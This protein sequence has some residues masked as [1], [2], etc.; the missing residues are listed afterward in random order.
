M[1]AFEKA[2]K[3]E[4]I[5]RGKKQKWLLEQVG[6]I[7]GGNLDAT[8]IN[9]AIKGGLNVYPQVKIAIATVLG[10]RFTTT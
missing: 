1:T 7:Y 5:K 2:V 4:L 3:T 6:K 8:V 9:K 10:I